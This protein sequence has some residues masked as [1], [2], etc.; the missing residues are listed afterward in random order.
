ARQM[1]AD[2]L[3][4]RAPQSNLGG[5]YPEN[6]V[7]ISPVRVIGPDPE[8]FPHIR[9]R[10]RGLYMHS[11]QDTSFQ[12]TLLMDAMTS[13]YGLSG[14]SRVKIDG[15]DFFSAGLDGFTIQFIR[16]SSQDPLSTTPVIASAILGTGERPCPIATPG[17]Y[18]VEGAYMQVNG[19]VFGDDWHIWVLVHCVDFVRASNLGMPRRLLNRGDEISR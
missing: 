7:Q 3:Q 9:E 15:A 8:Q 1:L 12:D 4:K 5:R 18:F 19:D 17:W 10:K 13:V 6:S 2:K 16:S 11:D 14:G